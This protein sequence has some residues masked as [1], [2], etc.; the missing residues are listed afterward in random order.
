L[1]LVT[2]AGYTAHVEQTQHWVIVMAHARKS[3][4]NLA[5]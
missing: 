3:S 1:T 2:D 4:A 5:V